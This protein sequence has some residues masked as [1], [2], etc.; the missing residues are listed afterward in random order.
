MI[1]GVPEELSLDIQ[2]TYTSKVT[3][4]FLKAWE[5]K[6]RLSSTYFPN[7]ITRAE[8]GVKMKRLMRNNTRPRCEL[9]N[10]AFAWV[11]LM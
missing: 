4:D 11:L 6:H 2:S 3:R 9:A 7:P 10:D 8:L 1:I 5:V